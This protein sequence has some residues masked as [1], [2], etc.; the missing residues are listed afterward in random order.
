MSKAIQDF[1]VPLQFFLK[2]NNQNQVL[3]NYE[4]NSEI[5]IL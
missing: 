4:N 3:I 1:M 2:K 5:N